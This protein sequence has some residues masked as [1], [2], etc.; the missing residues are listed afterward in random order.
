MIPMELRVFDLK[1]VRMSWSFVKVV[2]E[3]EK[4]MEIFRHKDFGGEYHACLYY[5]E[6]HSMKFN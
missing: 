2:E 6:N 1:V 4:V 5:R 3:F